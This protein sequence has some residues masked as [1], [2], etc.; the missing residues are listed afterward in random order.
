M[1]PRDPHEPRLIAWVRNPRVRRTLTLWFLWGF[2]AIGL[3]W[4]R[5][6]LL[7]FGLAILFAFIIEPMVE[8]A[9]RRKI[10]GRISIPRIAV[11]LSIYAVAGGVVYLF[12]Q[13]TLPQ[14]GRELAKLGAE[15]KQMLVDLERHG[16]ALLDRA[17][18]ISEE[19]H[20]PFDRTEIEAFVREYF[21]SLQSSAR[22]NLNNVFSFG[23]DVI[24][25]LFQGVFGLFLV[26]MLT[27]FL[28]MDRERIERYAHS[29]VPPE[30]RED[31][32]RLL[33]GV[34]GGLAGVVRG[35]LLIC[36]TN[37]VLTFIGLALLGVKFKIILAT[38]AAVFSLIPIFGSIISTLPIVAVALTDSF[39][40]AVF[41]LFW[42]VGIHLLEANLLNPKIMGDAARIHP[43]LV[44]FAL[45]AGERTAGLI[46]ALFAVPIASVVATFFRF[47]H[48]RAVEAANA[49]SRGGSAS[50]ASGT[51]NLP[52]GTWDP[53]GTGDLG[54]AGEEGPTSGPTTIP[55][56]PPSGPNQV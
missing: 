54:A 6:S 47:L 28:S 41:V 25:T 51:G 56:P 11:I 44:V 53:G 9:S 4:F 3:Y 16:L 15:S 22:A 33:R 5:L 23:R 43:V 39:P 10:A 49:P 29:L 48:T 17:V 8:F 12:G 46:G 36:L 30:S 42:I 27:A 45:V 37:G 1:F 2:A 13:W 50:W 40:K 52:R 32:T 55:P 18:Q 31:Y 35:Q 38:M 19:A 34:A 14:I 26:L 21:A 7:P 20:L 24:T